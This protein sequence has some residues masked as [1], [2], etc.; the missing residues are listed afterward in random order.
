[1]AAREGDPLHD[2]IGV[3]LVRIAGASSTPPAWFGAWYRLRPESP[4]EARLAVYQAVRNARAVP[5]EAGFFL[6]SWQIDAL[7]L[8]DAK[9]SLREHQDRL[10]AI[11]EARGGEEDAEYAAA[12]RQLH[13][14]W[15]A[16]YAKQ[17]EA[18]GEQE[19]ARLFRDDRVRFEHLSEAGRQFFQQAG[20]E[21]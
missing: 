21:P 11:C 20:A 19:A 12:E 9:D 6:V 13:E 5:E 15:D 14:A 18:F 10:E 4:E 17:L 3:R 7:T 8:R 2:A 1:M 16:L